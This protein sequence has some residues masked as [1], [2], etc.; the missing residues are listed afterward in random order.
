ML[1]LP[2]ALAHL[3]A[4]AFAV[5]STCPSAR[6]NGRGPQP[7]PLT[8]TIYGYQIGEEADPQ[9]CGLPGLVY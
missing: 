9:L 4:P 3:D 1:E 7:G 2:E 5:P 8:L 6:S